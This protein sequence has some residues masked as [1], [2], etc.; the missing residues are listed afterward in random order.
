MCEIWHTY[1]VPTKPQSKSESLADVQRWLQQQTANLWPLLLALSA[2]AVVPA[3]VRI[4]LPVF[5]GRNIPVMS[6]MVVRKDAAFPCTCRRNWFPKFSVGWTTGVR[7]R[8]CC[9][10]P[11][12]GISKL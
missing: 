4:V 2:F 10:K 12:R 3:F 11:R 1:T 5:P 8:T 9:T 7:C 6:F